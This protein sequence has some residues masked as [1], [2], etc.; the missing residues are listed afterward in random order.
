MSLDSCRRPEEPPTTII[1]QTILDALEKQPFSSLHELAEFTC[2]PTTAV[3]RHLKQLLGFVVRHL[4]WVP[5]S[6]TATQKT[7]RVTLSNISLRQLRSIEHRGWQFFI[8]FDV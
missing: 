7:E 1:Y 4:H 3:P 6:L 8:T 2:I 5:H